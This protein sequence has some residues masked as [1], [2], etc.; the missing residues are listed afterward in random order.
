MCKAKWV[1]VTLTG[2]DSKGVTVLH[3]IHG[4]K[5]WQYASKYPG[6][7]KILDNYDLMDK[8]RVT[9]RVVAGKG[10]TK[11]RLP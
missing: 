7:D 3:D 11:R 5:H 9:Y 6:W 1:T 2:A 10:I 4:T 8:P